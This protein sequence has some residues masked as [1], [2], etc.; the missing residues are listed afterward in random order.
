MNVHIESI[1]YQFLTITQQQLNKLV[2]L[3]VD[4]K[5]RN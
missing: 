4:C 2:N 3:S 5:R 1:K